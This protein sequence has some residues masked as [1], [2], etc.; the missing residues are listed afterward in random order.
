M[1]RN[2]RIANLQR[3]AALPWTDDGRCVVQHASNPW[4]AVVERCFYA[5]DTG[6]IRFHDIERRCTVASADAASLQTMVGLCLL[7]QPEL[8]VGAVI[9]I[10]VV[11]AAVAI[12]EALDAY[13]L[14]DHPEDAKPVPET[15][16]RPGTKPVTQEPTAEPTPKPEASPPGT[17][18]PPPV[19][20]EPPGPERSEC[21]P[22]PVPH[23][24]GDVLHNQCAD[25]VPQRDFPGSDVLVGGKHFDAVQ[26]RARVL[27]E[28]KTDKF[29]S[30]TPDL[31]EIV[32]KKQVAELLRELNLAKACGFDFRVGVRSAT[33]KVELERQTPELAG[34]IVV[35]DW[36]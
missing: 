33:H 12:K 9:V 36:C 15:R 35:M 32:I 34:R 14:S 17:K 1:T 18:W 16:P 25:R 13:E 11:V 27:W 31:Q 19:P 24:G 30:Y 10:G 7:A 6:R 28:V 23:L 20:T 22:R 5:L 3:A 29:D 4:P 26:L 8:L 21:T 2:P